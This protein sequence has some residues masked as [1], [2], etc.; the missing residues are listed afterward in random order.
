MSHQGN[1]WDREYNNPSFVTKHDEPQAD[2]K[3]FLKFLKKEEKYQHMNLMHH[4]PL[5]LIIIIN[6]II[7]LIFSP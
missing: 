4:C 2:T 1:I 3:R 7:F 5:H 6:L